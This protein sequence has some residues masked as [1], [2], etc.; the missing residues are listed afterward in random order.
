[1]ASGNEAEGVEW[2]KRF[3]E[4]QAQP[5]VEIDKA[6]RE[7]EEARQQTRKTTLTEMLAAAHDKFQ[8]RF[9]VE[10]NPD[11][12]TKGTYTQPNGRMHP[13]YLNPRLE[14]PDLQTKEFQL[15]SKE[16]EPNGEDLINKTVRSE[17]DIMSYH[18]TYMNNFVGGLVRACGPQVFIYNNSNMLQPARDRET[19]PAS[20]ATDHSPAPP[21]SLQAD[22]FYG[23]M[24]ASGKASIV[25]AGELKPPHKITLEQCQEIMGKGQEVDVKK[26][27]AVELIAITTCQIYDY[28]V[29]LGCVYGCIITGETIIFLRF[30]DE[31]PKILRYHL[32]CPRDEVNASVGEKLQY[33]KTAIAQL[34][35]FTLMAREDGLRDQVWKREVKRRADRWV[36][37]QEKTPKNTPRKERERNE[38]HEEKDTTF[39]NNEVEGDDNEDNTVRSPSM[40]RKR[41]HTQCKPYSS[42]NESHHPDSDEEREERSRR[43]SRRLALLNS[44]S[45]KHNET[46][47]SDSRKHSETET[48][49]SRKYSETETSSK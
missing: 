42:D 9:V 11:L 39:A 20:R 7:R 14:F 5:T 43:T 30:N 23:S 10:S 47:T 31:N 33:S 41:P 37:K 44:S 38:A 4:L 6:Q 36:P 28:M 8:E 34:A 46:E 19:H 3:E 35:S 21:Y 2:Q 22:Q 27:D 17:Q 49:K 15:M 29:N 26:H 32:T 12:R 13:Q 45:R 16:L 1:M 18:N 25:F 24:D 40:T 48:S